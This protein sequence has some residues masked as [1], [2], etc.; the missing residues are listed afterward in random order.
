MS[1]DH[2]D[3]TPLGSAEPTTAERSSLTSTAVEDAIA[4]SQLEGR[5]IDEE[6]I[7]LLHRV[8]AGELTADEAVQQALQHN[9]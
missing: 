5:I 7:A 8:V 2:V 6:T 1:T 9:E 4:S 3:A